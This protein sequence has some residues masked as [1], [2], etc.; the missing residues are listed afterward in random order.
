MS[1][2][3]K[4]LEYDFVCIGSGPAG[5][6]AAMQA[7][8]AGKRVAIIERRKHIG[9]VSLHAGTIP[10]KT[11]RAAILYLSGLYQKSFYGKQ[12]SLKTKIS[13]KDIRYRVERVLEEETQVLQDQMNRNGVDVFRGQAEFLDKHT[14]KVT[15]KGSKDELTIRSETIL[16]ATGSIPRRPTDIPF[17][18]Q[19]LFD[20]NLF[21]SN[22]TKRRKLPDSIIVVG[23]GVIGMEY[24]CMFA[25]LGIQ[26]TVVNEKEHIMGYLD[27]DIFHL[28]KRHMLNL[29]VRFILGHKVQA[30]K[31]SNDGHAQ[32][33]LEGHRPIRA[34]VLH[35]ALGREPCINS[36]RLDRV[37]IE[38]GKRNH[39]LVNRTYQTNVENIY[40]AGDV[41]GFPS[42]ASASAEQGRIAA[43]HAVGIEWTDTRETFPFGIY[44]I[45]AI[46]MVGFT[47]EDLKKKEVPYATGIAFYREIA[48]GVMMGDEAG[49]LKILFHPQT[50]EVLGVHCIGDQAPEIVHIG[51]AVMGLGGTIDFFVN[52]I[53][54]YPTYAEAY[55]VAALNGINSLEGKATYSSLLDVEPQ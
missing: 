40:A 18:Y 1:K 23:A 17:D 45:P 41:I 14:L 9:G 10:S 12:Y 11:M 46:S 30:V 25:T 27:G 29:G 48:K 8:K 52:N 34:D 43:C 2:N 38:L 13:L 47:E 16:I 53:F 50:R 49:A 42:L 6:N 21:F 51:Q 55:K 36:L 26:V 37:G 33:E 4:T 28:L 31:R 20:G 19:V 24:A 44:T 22:K 7:A 32:L 5:K 39:I 35:Y 15:C 54:N 3:V